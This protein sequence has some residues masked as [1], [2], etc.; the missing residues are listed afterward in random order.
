MRHCL[1]RFRHPRTHELQR[2]AILR[3]E[4]DAFAPAN[5]DRAFSLLGFCLAPQL[6]QPSRSAPVPRTRASSSALLLRPS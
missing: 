3:P 6:R 4:A 2:N 5:V 1:A